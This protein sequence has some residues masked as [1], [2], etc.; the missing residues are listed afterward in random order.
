MEELEGFGNIDLSY[1]GYFASAA[2]SRAMVLSLAP[3]R[4]YGD[5]L[6]GTGSPDL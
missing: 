4:N 3:V 6:S 1:L 2:I 5:I